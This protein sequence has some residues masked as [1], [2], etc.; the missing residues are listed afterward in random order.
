MTAD[1]VE[2]PFF[3]YSHLQHILL[4]CKDLGCEEVSP[5]L[6]VRDAVIPVTVFAPAEAQIL[7]AW[8]AHD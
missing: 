1:A 8:L 5:Q 7:D 3:D 2:M 4:H 6:G